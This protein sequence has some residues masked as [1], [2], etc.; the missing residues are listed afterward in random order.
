MGAAAQSKTAWKTTWMAGLGLLLVASD[1]S[2]AATGSLSEVNPPAPSSAEATTQAVELLKAGKS[3]HRIVVEPT[4][5]PSEKHAAEEL[6]RYV[7]ACAGVVLPVI[8]GV[9]SHP[10]PMIVLGC[11][12]MARGLGVDPA[13][14]TLGEQ[15]FVLRARGPHLLIAGTPDA[16]TLY[17]V[18][19][20]L[21]SY[22][23]VRWFAPDVTKTPK[24]TD[25]VIQPTQ[26]VVRPA[27][28]YRNVSYAWPGSD[29]GFRAR[30]GDNAGGGGATH[31]QGIQYAFDGTCHSYFNYVSPAEFFPTHPEYFSEIGGVRI[32]EET[33]LCLSNP[34][35]LDIV[36][37]RMLERMKAR[38]GVRQH[39]FSQMDYYNPCQCASC[40]RIND[41]LGTPGGTQYWFVNRLAERTS[42]LFPGKLIS[43]LAYTYTE[44]PPKE[45]QMHTNVAVWLCHMF[46]SC[47]SHPIVSCPLNADYQRRARAWSKITS[48]LYAWHYIVDFAHYYSPFPNFRAMAADLRFY[49]RIGVE[50]VFLQGMGDGGGGGEFSLLR[51]Y[52]GL[53]LL[54]DPEQAPDTLIRDFLDGYYGAAARP[55]WE[56]IQLLHD[57]V[58]QEGLHMHLYTNPAQGYLPDGLL[59]RAAALFD[60]AETLAG[61]DAELLDRVRVARLPLLY[62]RLFPRNGYR[63]AGEELVWQGEMG[64]PAEALAFVDTL[65]RHGFQTIR[66][67]GGDPQ[68]MITL[69][70]MLA[71]RPKVF[72]IQN[73][74]LRVEVV[75]ALGGRALR[76]TDLN[77][78]QCVTAHNTRRHLFFPFCG[79][80]EDRVGE[81]F[82]SDGW[83][84]PALVPSHGS[85]AITT[86][87]AT[88]GGF[89]LTRRLALEPGQ[90]I[91]RVET[92]LTNRG[93]KAH[94]AR[95]RHHLEL[96]LGD[97]RKID[98]VFTNRAGRQIHTPIAEVIRGL[99]EGRHF[100]SE[101]AP[102]GEW[103]L[104][105]G[106]GL[107][108]RQRFDNDRADFTWLHAFPEAL[109]QLE[110]EVW[111]KRTMLNPEQSLTVVQEIEVQTTDR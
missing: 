11:G 47:D 32:A 59:R 25:L 92:M 49:R 93:N 40:R 101:L 88:A 33:Q 102:A 90:P 110:T 42:K 106:N 104:Q 55:I 46:P 100:Y 37:E 9:P 26:Q 28:R 24:V 82:W 43:T 30:L 6:A 10:G 7:E 44:E 67:M 53:K 61:R 72:T 68:Q 105:G 83:S 48:H 89:G 41:E 52:Y 5:S 54:W 79:G 78:G 23:G 38:P 45:L 57:K 66:E 107:Q 73:G 16:G 86:V 109:G 17:G 103:T 77:S 62:A 34:E 31:P 81:V 12:P 4:A 80:L 95:L 58:E 27:F 75:P 111:M 56:Y 29:P 22:L 87:Q 39:N 21:E 64:S 8:A 63:I 36:T 98:C 76:I 14:E 65:K 97:L 71:S 69:G 96:A 13:P 84:E 20:F 1:F 108:V 70:S 74:Y 15:G 19:R 94:G 2:W 85:S 3:S 35:V 91:L 99:R 51:P 18:Y 50:G 60:Q